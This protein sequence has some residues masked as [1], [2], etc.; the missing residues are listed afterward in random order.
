MKSYPKLIISVIITLSA[1]F[2]GSFFTSSS[3]DTW[4]ASLNKPSF[5]PPNWL[6]VPVWTSLFILIGISF[7]LVWRKN[8]EG[9][10]NLAVGVYSIQLSLN[11]LWSFFFFGLE[12]PFFALMEI[13]LLWAFILANMNIFYKISKPAAFLLLPY[14]FWVSFALILNYFI[15]KLN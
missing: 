13:I 8:F 10:R 4:Y 9:R 5:N 6:F 7:Y 1:G 15:F 3:I 2:L 14:L 12:N 11:L